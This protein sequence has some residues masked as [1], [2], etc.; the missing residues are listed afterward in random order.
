M[1]IP[2]PPTGAPDQSVNQDAGAQLSQGMQVLVTSVRGL[3]RVIA[4]QTAMMERTLSASSR[5][6]M[7]GQRQFRQDVLQEVAGAGASLHGARTTQVTP[8]GA[9]SSLQNLQSF[10]AQRIGQWIAGVPLYEQPG[11]GPSAPSGGTPVGTPSSQTMGGPVGTPVP[12]GSQGGGS[13]GGPPGAAPPAA[14]AG[15]PPRRG[16]SATPPPATVQQPPGAGLSGLPGYLFGGQN[17]AAPPPR[18]MAALRQVG[19]R[20]AMSSGSL[21]GIMGVLKDLPGVGL[22]TDLA[23]GAADFYLN[24]REAGRVYQETEGGSNLAAQAERWHALAYEASM[25]GRMP[26]GAA[27]QAFGQV[28]ALGYNR[29]SAGSEASQGQNRQS[30]LDFIYHNYTAYGMDVQQSVEILRTASQN[31][32]NNLNTVSEALKTVSDTAGQAGNNANVMRQY[33]NSYFQQAQQLGAGGGSP[34]LAGALASMQASMGKE[35]AGVNFGGELSQARQYLLSGMSGVSPAQLQYTARNNPQQ[36]ARLLAGQNLQFLTQGGLMT[37]EMQASLHQMISAAGG[38]TALLSNPGLRDQIAQQ[39]LNEWQVKGNIN[40]NVWAQEISMLTGVKMNPDQAFQWIVSQSAGVN[41]ASHN[42][43]FRSPSGSAVRPAPG[44]STGS[45]P[46]GQFGLAQARLVTT[47]GVGS[48]LVPSR[49]QTWRDVLTQGPAGAAAQNYLK[50]DTAHGHTRSPVLE[51]LLQNASGSDQVKVMTK[52]GPRV[53]PL[54]LAMKYYPQELAGG[55]VEFYSSSGQQLGDTA[56][57]THGL[58]NNNANTAGEMHQATGSKQ[59]LSLSKYNA[60]HPGSAT[61]PAGGGHSVTV[62]LSNAAQQLLKLLPNNYDQ[63]AATSQV[64]ANPWPSQA[65]R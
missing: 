30:A 18:A 58:V 17:A 51:A 63:A 35:F 29:A 7:G 14:P 45:A 11:G 15:P 40:E 65:S 22:I 28:T 26:S 43:A 20:V 19:A 41:E 16:P 56:M 33:F 55:N 9:A 37:P 49:Y 6:Q 39:F 31:A 59:G 2:F 24:Q 1:T 57:I 62:D 36:Y 52:T 50:F 8:L 48:R 53:M 60:A 10:A 12:A 38:G 27:A 25:F 5:Y 46:R 34:V 61:V 13:P 47:P 42:S 64:P 54:S 3:E 21:S 23:Q 4:T 44:G 32:V